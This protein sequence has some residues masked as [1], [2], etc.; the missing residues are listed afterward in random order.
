MLEEKKGENLAFSLVGGNFCML[1]D[2]LTIEYNE[3][4][5]IWPFVPYFVGT[6]GRADHFGLQCK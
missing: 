3:C 4:V 5:L 2:F 6:A 1:E